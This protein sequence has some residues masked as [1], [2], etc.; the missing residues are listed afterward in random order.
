M[1][2]WHFI[3]LLN[4]YFHKIDHFD[5][6]LSLIESSKAEGAKV[7]AGGEQISREGK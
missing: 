3:I 5:K 1:F 6:C 4:N 7:I 2:K